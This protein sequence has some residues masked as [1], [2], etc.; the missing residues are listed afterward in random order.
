MITHR[1]KVRVIDESANY[2]KI[3]NLTTTH[4]FCFIYE[5]NYEQT[6]QML[7]NV[8]M[9]QHTNASTFATMQN[10]ATHVRVGKD[11]NYKATN[12]LAKVTVYFVM[13]LFMFCLHE[14]QF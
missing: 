4:C 3:M 6:L 1:V 5:Q 10:P 11:T 8:T 9:R 7:T 2:K 13:L 14:I 12:C